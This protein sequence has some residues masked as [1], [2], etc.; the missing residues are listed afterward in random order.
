[1]WMGVIG[2]GLLFL[3]WLLFAVFYGLG[4]FLD[5]TCVNLSDHYYLDCSLEPGKTCQRAKLTDFFQCPEITKVSDYYKKAWN[6]LDTANG[7]GAGT[8][9]YGD[10]AFML[11]KAYG[12]TSPGAVTMAPAA[13]SATCGTSACN[14]AL[15]MEPYTTCTNGYRFNQADT[16]LNTYINTPIAGNRRSLCETGDINSGTAAP[17]NMELAEQ[18][19]STNPHWAAASC[20]RACLNASATSGAILDSLSNFGGNCMFRKFVY[21]SFTTV[22]VSGSQGYAT[23]GDGASSKIAWKDNSYITDNANFQNYSSWM[24]TYSSGSA[25]DPCIPSSACSTTNGQIPFSTTPSSNNAACFQAATMAVSDIMY[26]L[27]YIASCQYIKSFALLTAVESTGACFDLG[28]GLLYLTAAQGLIGVGF[29]IVTVV[30]IMGYRRWQSDNYEENKK[31]HQEKS[32]V[33]DDVGIDKDEEA[34]QD[35]GAN[36]EGTSTEMTGNPVGPTETAGGSGLQP[37]LQAQ[38]TTRDKWV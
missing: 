2:A 20:D 26:A 5:D 12:S 8:N 36:D 10:T 11:N 33:Y 27:S 25:T 6:L 19:G 3:T 18:A 31:D 38:T 4:V 9:E 28:D 34:P 16:A 1:M 29:F 35:M 15:G 17:Q 13:I 14:N 32:D 21:E 37:G 24:T 7:N 23:C 22:Y 30:G